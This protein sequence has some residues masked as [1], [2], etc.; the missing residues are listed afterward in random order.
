M[1]FVWIDIGIA[2]ILLISIIVAIFRGFVKEA[3]SL[4]TWIVAVWLAITFSDQ[5]ALLLPESIDEAAFNLASIELAAGK[6][7]A[8]VA[9]LLIITGTLI[10][11]AV[12]NYALGHITQIHALRGIDRVLGAFFGL[13]R[14]IVVIALI[15]L[16]TTLTSFSHSDTWKS[17]QLLPPFELVAHKM[18]GFMP[19]EYAKYFSFGETQKQVSAYQ[20]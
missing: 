14:G 18:T 19:S 6:L 9:F 7:R 11:G 20:L 10:A 15:I 12:L 13:V 16:V 2:V 17:S 3:I 1:A 4:T 5:V 8:G